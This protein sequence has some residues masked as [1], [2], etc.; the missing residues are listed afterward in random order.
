MSTFDSSRRVAPWLAVF[1]AGLFVSSA[2]C[3]QILGIKEAQL[4]T[5]TGGSGGSGGSGNGGSGGSTSDGGGSSGG[6][7]GDGGGGTGGST[8]TSCESIPVASLPA[9]LVAGCVYRAS[10]DPLGTYTISYCLSYGTQTLTTV[11]ACTYGATSCTWVDECLER[12]YIEK[13]AAN[14]FCDPS[15]SDWACDGN[16]AVYCG[17][18]DYAFNI[19]CSALG[20]TCTPYPLGATDSGIAACAL[21]DTNGGGCEDPAGEFHCEGNVRYECIGGIKYGGDCTA[22]D[23]TCVESEQGGDAYCLDS[24]TSCEN[25]GASVCSDSTLNSCLQDGYSVAF[26][27]A[28]AG[29]SCAEEGYCLAPGCTSDDADACVESCSGTSL[30]VCVGGSPMLIDCNTLGF[31]GC[32]TW[33]TDLIHAYCYGSLPDVNS[34]ELAYDGHCDEPD[35]CQDGS[36]TFDCTYAAGPDSCMYANDD[37][38]DEPDLCDP[39]TDTTDCGGGN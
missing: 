5:E 38:C 23:A 8:P 9:E 11:E 37:F 32:T 34:C 17:G 4:A 16:F 31:E 7:S 30:Q 2:G 29:L 20:G 27:C 18:S 33:G 15:V 26:D 28:A 36:D 13:A 3:N 24:T 35:T 25:R 21:N 12:G 10:C 19:D 1:A 14:E 6:S 39:G 22:S